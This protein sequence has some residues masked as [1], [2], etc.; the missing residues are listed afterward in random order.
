MDRAGGL[1]ISSNGPLKADVHIFLPL[2]LILSCGESSL[3]AI[4][5]SYHILLDTALREK[6]SRGKNVFLNGSRLLALSATDLKK[7]QPCLPLPKVETL[8]KSNV[9]DALLAK[10]LLDELPQL[11]RLYLELDQ[12][13]ERGGSEV[14]DSYVSRINTV[15]PAALVESLNRC[16]KSSHYAA[17]LECQSRQFVEIEQ[18]CEKQYL[19]TRDLAFKF[20]HAHRMVRKYEALMDRYLSLELNSML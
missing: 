3:E 10:V 5:D 9:L 20:K 14:D 17:N 8:F 2:D 15:D 1:P 16:N 19:L 18:E 11:L 7:W 4:E 13:S 12:C 6:S